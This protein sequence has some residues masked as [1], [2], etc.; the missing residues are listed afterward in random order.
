MILLIAAEL[1]PLRVGPSRK[2]ITSGRKPSS[3]SS[4]Q[5]LSHRKGELSKQA[6]KA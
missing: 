3:R 2:G 6:R 5:T 1:K 4:I